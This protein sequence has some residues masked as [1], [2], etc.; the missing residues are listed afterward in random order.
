MLVLIVLVA[1]VIL[2]VFDILVTVV[3]LVAIAL[4]LVVVVAAVVALLGVLEFVIHNWR[5]VFRVA[6]RRVTR[7]VDGT[8]GTVFRYTA[9]RMSKRRHGPWPFGPVGE[10]TQIMSV[11]EQTT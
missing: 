3:I 1:V 4:V 5:F 2:A 11:A 8:I 10:G 6:R 9:R 7:L